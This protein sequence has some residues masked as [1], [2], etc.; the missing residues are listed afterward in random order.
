MSEN[1]AAWK[2]DN[3]GFKEDTFIQTGR[4]RRVA[5]MGREAAWCGKAAAGRRM[6]GRDTLGENDPSPSQTTLPRVPSP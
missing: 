2:S 4:R 5:E 6:D 1:R 3:Q